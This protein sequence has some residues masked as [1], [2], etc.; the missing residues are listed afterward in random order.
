[1]LCSGFMFWSGFMLCSG[2]MSCSR[3]MLCSGFMS[4]SGFMLMA[5]VFTYKQGPVCNWTLRVWKTFIRTVE[6]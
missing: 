4:C 3:F 2:F 1:M 5:V 6:T